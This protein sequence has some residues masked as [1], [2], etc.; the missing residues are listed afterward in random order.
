MRSLLALLVLATFTGTAKANH[1]E[2]VASLLGGGI[3]LPL[4]EL[5][6]EYSEP[7]MIAV[8]WDAGAAIQ[9]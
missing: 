3:I 2:L 6:G 8:P 9:S 4:P 5:V 7:A 1:S